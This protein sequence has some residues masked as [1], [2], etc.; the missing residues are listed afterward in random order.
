[1]KFSFIIPSI[2]RKK[3]V[4]QLLKSIKNTVK[5]TY[6]VIIVDQNN[7]ALLDDI[8]NEFKESINIRH[9]KVS[10]K[11]AS[12]ARNYGVRFAKGEIINFPDDD[13]EFSDK[14]IKNVCDS[15]KT[16]QQVD[17]VFGKAVDKSNMQ[18][19]IIKFK[20]NKE[21]VN[22]NNIYKTTVEFTMFMK[23]DSFINLGG[24]DENLGVGT[25]CG[26]DEGADF[27]IR[28][29][30]AKKKIIYNPEIIFFHPQKGKVYDEKDIERALKYGR[31]FGALTY[32]HIK[33]KN[34]RVLVMSIKF[35]IKAM[36]GMIV[37]I[38]KGNKGM[39]K[40]YKNTI[41]GRFQG[42]IYRKEQH[43]AQLS[44]NKR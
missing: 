28:A 20:N 22:F 31:G 15:F 11:G 13:S 12:K 18:S 36:I 43:T 33:L 8:V 37:G 24:F 3:E 27:V 23:K 25:Y 2:G 7:N 10:F 38:L 17:I 34:Y 14:L 42:F 32:K 26:A 19:S 6:E 29:L 9:L 35:N 40:F 4:A 16:G 21:I 1:M 39:F 41:K 44:I 30:N 5:Y